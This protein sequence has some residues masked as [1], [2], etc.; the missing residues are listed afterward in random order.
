VAKRRLFQKN[1]LAIIR[2]RPCAALDHARKIHLHGAGHDLRA[3][4][5][6]GIFINIG[7]SDPTDRREVAG[8]VIPI[9]FLDRNTGHKIPKAKHVRERRAIFRIKP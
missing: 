4:E 7:F 9:D 6:A 2:L 5:S 8:P 3:R 1:R